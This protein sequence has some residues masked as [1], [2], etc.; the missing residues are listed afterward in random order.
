[1]IIWISYENN[2]FYFAKELIQ[3]IL[4]ISMLPGQKSINIS[5]LTADKFVSFGRQASISNGK[6]GHFFVADFNRGIPPI[7]KNIA[8]CVTILG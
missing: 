2:E 5:Y 3:Q 8:V 4:Q 6:L 7:N 1:M